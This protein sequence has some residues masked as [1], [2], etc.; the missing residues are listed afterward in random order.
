MIRRVLVVL[1]IFSALILSSCIG[2]AG[3][4]TGNWEVTYNGF[5]TTTDESGAVA[6]SKSGFKVVVAIPDLNELKMRL[7]FTD[8]VLV[9]GEESKT[10]VFD[11]VPVFVTTPDGTSALNYIIDQPNATPIVDGVLATE[12]A[13]KDLQA[14]L[15]GTGATIRFT[16]EAKPSYKVE[17]TTESKQ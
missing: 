7:T 15:S 14:A 13:V 3:G 1:S 10:L 11:A 2:K 12:L 9:E 4:I 8:F 5:L 6:Y 16:T 17:F